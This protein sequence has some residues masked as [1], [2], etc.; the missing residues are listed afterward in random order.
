MLLRRSAHWHVVAVL[1]AALFAVPALAHAQ[2]M[3]FLVR[4]AERADDGAAAAGM[5]AQTDPELSDV[6]RARAARL[7]T[8]LGDAGISAVFATE[9]R[10][11]QDTGKPLATKLGVTVTT[12]GARDADALLAQLKSDHADDI[13]LVVG[14]SNTVPALIRALGGPT[15]TMGEDEYDSLFVMVPSTGAF[16]RIRY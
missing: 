6:G 16:T 13:V 11:T 9:Y 4:H 15:F 3:V 12:V 2:Q 10:R 7:A 1:L 5:Q 8:M 14:H